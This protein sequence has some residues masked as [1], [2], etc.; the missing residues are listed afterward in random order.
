MICKFTFVSYHVS[1][2]KSLY[3]DFVSVVCLDNC[4]DVF[5]AGKEDGDLLLESFSVNNLHLFRLYRQSPSRAP[6][7]HLDRVYRHDISL[8]FLVPLT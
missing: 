7:R 2:L 8:T 1:Y 5:N 6:V 3:Y 4:I